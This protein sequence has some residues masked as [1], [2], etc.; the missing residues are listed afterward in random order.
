MN[1]LDRKVCVPVHKSKSVVASPSA[2]PSATLFLS[3][4]WTGTVNPLIQFTDFPTLLTQAAALAPEYISIV[5]YNGTYS[6]SY[7]IPPNVSEIVALSTETHSFSTITIVGNIFIQLS[8]IHVATVH[9]HSSIATVLNSVVTSTLFSDVNSVLNVIQN[10]S[11]RSI[12]SL[13]THGPTNL[14]GAYVLSLS[15]DGGITINDSHIQV[16]H[17]D[18]IF[19]TSYIYTSSFTNF[20]VDSGSD[21]VYIDGCFFGGAL[22]LSVGGL[23]VTNTR[24][25]DIQVANVNALTLTTSRIGTIFIRDTSTNVITA[26]NCYINSIQYFSTNMTNTTITAFNT[27]IGSIGN[28]QNNLIDQSINIFNH[29]VTVLG[30]AITFASISLPDYLDNH[31]VVQ[32]TSLGFTPMSVSIDPASITTTGF[33][34]YASADGTASFTISKTS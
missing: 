22:I 12:N 34:A 1:C 5:V 3:S 20:F 9:V 31:Y 23:F 10:V 32:A 16:M 13:V 29:A 8:N 26:D 2:L 7:T 19:G 27:T 25:Q 11:N 15:T 6:G 17:I 21:F 30:T 14:N 18:K 4:A 33:T 24:L 28:P